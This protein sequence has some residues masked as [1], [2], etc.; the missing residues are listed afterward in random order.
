M[1]AIICDSIL[2]ILK[3]KKELR[4]GWGAVPSTSLIWHTLLD[5]VVHGDTKLIKK[6]LRLLVPILNCPPVPLF[7]VHIGRRFADQ[8]LQSLSA[9]QSS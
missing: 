6:T 9:N 3:K 7:S 8:F 2:R 5:Q 1:A 4:V